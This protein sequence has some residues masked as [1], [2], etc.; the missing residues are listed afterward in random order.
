MQVTSPVSC[1]AGD[2]VL[3]KWQMLVELLSC[4][5]CLVALLGRAEVVCRAK[6]F[7][8][9]GIRLATRLQASRW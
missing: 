6:A 7:C 9:E 3:Q 5:E 4:M 8:L 2:N 1:G